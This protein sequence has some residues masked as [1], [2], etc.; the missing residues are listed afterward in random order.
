[1]ARMCSK[2]KDY[3]RPF[4]RKKYGQG[5]DG[6]KPKFITVSAPP[7]VAS[8]VSCGV[9]NA[10]APISR[11]TKAFGAVLSASLWTDTGGSPHASSPN[12]SSCS[13]AGISSMYH[14][15]L[16]LAAMTQQRTKWWQVTRSGG[17]ILGARTFT[18]K[19]FWG[20]CVLPITY[21][22]YLLCT[23]STGR[24]GEPLGLG[25]H[26]RLPESKRPV[27]FVMSDVNELLIQPL[28]KFSK[29]SMHLIKKCT[30]P[31][32]KGGA[33]ACSIFAGR[34]FLWGAGRCCWFR[35]RLLSSCS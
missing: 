14:S 2:Y 25:Y 12:S 16:S 8:T 28:Q 17:L 30:K 11:L 21:S 31:D 10:A 7:S 4:A 20:P 27:S 1:M 33:P 13:V 26:T 35:R 34:P 9:S 19:R 5:Y 18:G 24:T 6:C 3:G 15:W 32:R 22:V 23:P 29:D